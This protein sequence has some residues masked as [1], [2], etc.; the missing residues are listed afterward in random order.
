MTRYFTLDNDD[1]VVEVDN[2]S[3]YMRWVDSW[4]ACLIAQTVISESPCVWVA[5][6]FLGV[7]DNTTG[8]GPPC[9][10]ETRAFSDGQILDRRNSA[11]KADA[12]ACHDMVTAR[13]AKKAAE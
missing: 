5:T 10:F 2:R 12:I 4:P 13:W 7:D 3:A 11:T 9:P 8:E 6:I 1:K